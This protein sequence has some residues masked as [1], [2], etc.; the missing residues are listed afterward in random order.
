M[1]E[2]DNIP[3]V[4]EYQGVINWSQVPAP[5]AMMKVSDGSSY[6]D[7]QANHNYYAAKA[8]GKAVGMYHFAEGGDP[9]A[10]AL[11][12]IQAVSPLEEF[13]VLALDWEVQHADPVA[14]VQT[15]MSTVHD[16]TGVWP[17]L[18]INL[19][20]LNAYNWGPVL[21]NCGLWIADWAV[22]PQGT[23]PTSHVYVMQQY[24]DAGTI[25]GIAGRVDEDSWFGTVD[26]FK[27]YGYH[28]PQQPNPQPSPAPEPTPEPA[29]TPTPE[30]PSP[31]APDP[32]PTPTPEPT[33][34]PVP[35]PDPTPVPD[36]GTVVPPEPT[37]Q[38]G[39]VP[40]PQPPKSG[41]LSRLIAA[42]VNFVL[43]V[44]NA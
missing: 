6:F 20:T 4:S 28:A 13:D 33:P 31:P 39:P 44:W 43:K 12:F 3:D 32:T 23:I 10:E 15:F 35:T 30:P 18:Y 1:S 34:A 42:I 14:W 26:Q 7:K 37:P 8:A 38:P 41:L 21:L 19:A 29:P 36:P 22:P 9:F 11:H 25:P 40:T 24:T 27:E 17:L 16:R 2:I 5:I